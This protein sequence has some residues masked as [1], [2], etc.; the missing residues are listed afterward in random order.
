MGVRDALKSREGV[1]LL[2]GL[3]LIVG[4][5]AYL[6]LKPGGPE[7]RDYVGRWAARDEVIE[8]REDG[9]LGEVRLDGHSCLTGTARTDPLRAYQGTWQAGSVDD[10]GSGVFVTL[11]D[12]GHGADCRIYLQ[13]VRGGRQVATLGGEP[14]GSEQRAFTRA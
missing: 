10:A 11:R 2:V 5:T 6:K 1:V 12:S 7:A 13:E 8:L 3:L 14:R 4:V 9:T